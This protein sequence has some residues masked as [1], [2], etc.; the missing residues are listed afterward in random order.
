MNNFKS[1]HSPISALEL[2]R[3]YVY[4]PTEQW[5]R[6]EALRASTGLSVSQYISHLIIKAHEG[7]ESNDSTRICH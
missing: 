5:Q 2:Q 4:L 7:K 3:A 1:H 6:V